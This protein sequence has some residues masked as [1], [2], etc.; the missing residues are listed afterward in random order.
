MAEF[1][2]RV[3]AF[4]LAVWSSPLKLDKQKQTSSKVFKKCLCEEKSF[5]KETEEG[6]VTSKTKRSDKTRSES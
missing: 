1:L 5:S 6:P 2:M 3:K 4:V